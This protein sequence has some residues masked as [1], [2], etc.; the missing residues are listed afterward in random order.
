MKSPKM[1][2]IISFRVTE[3]D[4][5]RIEKAAADSRETPN[6]WCRMTALEMLKMPVGL[7]PNQCILFAQMARSTFLVENGFQLLA[8]ETLESDH[9]KKYRAYAR[10]NLNTITDRA[11]ED[12]RLRT[13]PG[14]GSGRR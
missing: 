5:L 3:E 13:E 10:T 12:H 1:S 2:R 6:D 7:T 8:D 9:W 11:L 4:W 14:G